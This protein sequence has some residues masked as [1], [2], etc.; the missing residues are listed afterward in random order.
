MP[1]NNKKGVAILGVVL[2]AL[3]ACASQAQQTVEP[4]APGFFHGL[5]HG[6]FILFSFV[7]SLFSDTIDIYAVPNN[8][9]WY[10]F[11][12]AL[13]AGAFGGSGVA[14]SRR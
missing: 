12:F 9:G 1:F 3:A 10:N 5:F 7:G 2:M 8:G 6:Y 11:G 14:A 4:Q 13:G